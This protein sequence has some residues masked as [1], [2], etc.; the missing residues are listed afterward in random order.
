MVTNEEQGQAG[1]SEADRARRRQIADA[2]YGV[3]PDVP[4]IQQFRVVVYLCGDPRT[5]FSEAR[6][7]CLTYAT[8]FGWVVEAVVE[9][10]DWLVAP[11]GR[12]GLCRAIEYVRERRAGAVLT[13]RGSMISSVPQECDE[14][15]RKIEK[16]GGFLQVMGTGRVRPSGD[17]HEEAP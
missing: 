13:P 10:R 8:A 16:L 6:Q 3:A 4:Q 15:A 2:A 1:R 12:T 17:L 7:E 14:T 11:S 5:D 9:D